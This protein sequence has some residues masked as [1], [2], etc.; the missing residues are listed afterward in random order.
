MSSK[1]TLHS[2]LNLTQK[3][4]LRV[5]LVV[6]FVVQIAAAVGLTTALSWR[7]GQKAIDDLATQLST[8][9]TNRIQEH[10]HTYLLQPNLLQRD[11]RSNLFHGDVP[12][13]NPDVVARHFWHQIQVSE[14]ITSIYLGYP[15]GRF[16]GVQK[17]DDGKKV[18]WEVTEETA[19]KRLTYRL[20]ESGQR[21]EEIGSQNYDPRERP[22]Y[23]AVVTNRHTSWSPIY[24]FASQDYSVLGITLAAPIHGDRGELKG[25]IALDLTL[26]QISSYLRK[27]DIS[28]SGEAFIIE[29]TGNIVATSTDEL[30]FLTSGTGE[31][32][33]LNA[34][35]ST[36]PI[37]RETTQHLTQKFGSLG[38]IDDAE[39]FTFESAQ[40]PQ[41]VQVVPFQDGRGLDWLV[42]TIIP[43]SDFKGQIAENTRNTLILCLLSLIVASVIAGITARW[44]AQPIYRLSEASKKLAVG[45][46][47]TSLPNGRF[48]E[49][50]ELSQSFESMAQ[51]I[52]QSFEQLEDHNRELK[53]IDKLKDE[54]L[55]NT[56]HELRTP[57]NGIIGLAESLID[58]VSGP[59]PRQTKSNLAMIVASGRRLSAL[60]D[61]IL[62]FS[63]LQHDRVDINLRPVGIREA[64]EVVITLSRPLAH[65]KQVQLINAVSHK[66]PPA[67][68]DENRLQQILHNL[69][70]N[71]VKFTEYGMVG[72]SAQIIKNP[73]AC[74]L[75]VRSRVPSTCNGASLSEASEA[76]N[77]HP[78]E[79]NGNGHAEVANTHTEIN[80]NGHAETAVLVE[81]DTVLTAIAPD[82]FS[83]N[84]NYYLAITVSDTGTGI[85]EDKLHRIFEP[86]VQAD[87]STSRIY[88]GMGIGLAVTKR[89]VE[90]QGGTMKVVSSVGVGSQFTFTLPV[91]P[92]AGR[93]ISDRP[94]VEQVLLKES[95]LESPVDFRWPIQAVS[96]SQLGYA[97]MPNGENGHDGTMRVMAQ[98]QHMVLVVDDE[99]INRQVIMNHLSVQNYRVVQAADGPEALALIE[100]G[101]QPDIVLLDVMMPRMTGFEV[102]RKLRETYPAHSLPIV[103]LTAKNQV[104]SLVEGLSAGANDYLT[105]P[106]SKSELVARLKTHLYL[107]KINQAYGRFV[108]REFLQFLNKESIVE[109]ELGDQVQQHM[110]VLFADIRDFTSLSEQMTPE[111]NFKFINAFLSRMEPAISENHGFIDKY[112]GDAIM[113]LFSRGADD[114]LQASV[115]MLKRLHQY[116]QK[117]REY[118]KSIIEIGIGINTGSLMLG[119]VGGCNRMDSTVISDT[120]N[121]AS[122]IE[123]MTRFY[124]VN[125]LISHHTFLQLS[126]PNDYAMRVIDRVQA[127]GK[128]AYIS[129]YEVFDPDP[130][131]QR[132][133]KLKSRTLFEQALAIYN[134]QCYGDALQKFQHCLEICPSDTVAQSYLERCRERAEQG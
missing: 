88:G 61:D 20:N 58:G 52:K 77:T 25:V 117:R 97:E 32:T 9:A 89:L 48:Q 105:K 134:Q 124:D 102:C 82:D 44:V 35:A 78:T 119:T 108:P 49:L 47:E 106:I 101:V 30:P 131:E 66:L 28:A 23:R 34:T 81:K 96:P 3:L 85:P 99:P 129:V 128:I 90:L 46:W 132:E 133:G 37:I 57:L 38:N 112:I 125:L 43:E 126:N 84:S 22:W 123:R 6:S 18:L 110:S 65:Q 8:R 59:L 17:R 55:A 83:S 109:V 11:S 42:V 127:K 130:P 71:A 98:Q 40:E 45:T 100:D 33:R 93:L 69:V 14:G 13:S 103:M 62:D 39:Q 92:E 118:G 29:R 56:S 86:F 50:T 116:N 36:E 1:P 21:R 16:L 114:A 19:P 4:P 104:S 113:A 31:Q 12:L 67:L 79:M 121:V 54:F 73:D 15:D 80:G 68:A 115:A 95:N 122:R 60:V 72:I 111:Q 7:N 74:S 51:Q 27:I 91:S 107:A 26:E 94:E 53:R 87:G 24:E 2:V 70:G 63:Q 76:A 10:L 41:L 120:V 75:A 5:V 64:A